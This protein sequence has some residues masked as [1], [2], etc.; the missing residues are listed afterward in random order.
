LK[1]DPKAYQGLQDGHYVL[2][3]I[4]ELSSSLVL[5]YEKDPDLRGNRVVVFGDGS[6]KTLNEQDFQAALKNG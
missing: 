6:V 4:R 1:D 3:P 5:A 2:K